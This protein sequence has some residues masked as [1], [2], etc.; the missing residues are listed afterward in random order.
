MLSARA[1]GITGYSW[2]LSS[3]ALDILLLAVS[4]WFLAIR[5]MQSMEIGFLLLIRNPEE[6]AFSGIL[7]NRASY[8]L[9]NRTCQ[10]S[11][12]QVKFPISNS[13]QECLGFQVSN[14]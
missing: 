7:V 3:D 5:G 10:S 12:Q 8:E 2:G 6:K 11:N 1:R 13:L 14:L 9:C 4:M